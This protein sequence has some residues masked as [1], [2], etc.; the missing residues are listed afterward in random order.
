MRCFSGMDGLLLGV[1][2]DFG[3]IIPKP[4][5]WEP[6]VG[7]LNTLLCEVPLHRRHTLKLTQIKSVAFQPQ[8]RLQ[9][10]GATGTQFGER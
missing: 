8:Q 3:R 5:V 2:A 4:Y 9:D 10:V 1:G 6:M 7:N